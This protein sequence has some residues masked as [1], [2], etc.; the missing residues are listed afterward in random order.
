[1]KLNKYPLLIEI[2]FLIVMAI[3]V[4]LAFNCLRAENLC[5]TKDWNDLKLEQIKKDVETIE[6][7][8]A[9]ELLPKGDICF[10]DAREPELYAETHIEGARNIFPYSPDEKI[11]QLAKELPKGKLIIIY[12][13]SVSC[14]KSDKLAHKL[15][16]LGIKDVCVMPEGIEGWAMENGPLEGGF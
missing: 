14:D 16:A 13:D 9:L 12:C 6:V 15:V 2:L 7:L 1:M 8:N 4:G 10:V 3:A 5:I 11:S